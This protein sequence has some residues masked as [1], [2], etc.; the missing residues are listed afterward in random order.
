[1][2]LYVNRSAN[3]VTFEI[4]NEHLE[5]LGPEGQT[6]TIKPCKIP[7]SGEDGFV[8]SIED[9]YPPTTNLIAYLKA[10]KVRVVEE[11]KADLELREKVNLA[12]NEARVALGV[13]M[14]EMTIAMK[15]A[16]IPWELVWSGEGT[17]VLRN[18]SVLT[19]TASKVVGELSSSWDFNCF[20]VYFKDCLN[21][22]WI[23]LTSVFEGKTGLTPEKC[24]LQALKPVFNDVL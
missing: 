12:Y 14:F 23:V 15:D 11:R 1:M 9:P 19:V 8:L 18:T 2:I 16:G 4:P 22:E 7:S 24:L 20:G 5:R 17:V 13:S 3:G 6:I 10:E 21:S